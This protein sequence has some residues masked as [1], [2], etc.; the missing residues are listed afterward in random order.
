MGKDY[1][2]ILGLQKGASSDEIKKAFRKLASQYHPDKKT[3]DEAKFKEVSEAYAVLG[4][5]K[6]RAEYDTYGQSFAGGGGFNGF[7]WSN[8][9]GFGGNGVEFDLGDIFQNFG[10]M[11]GGFGR[12]ERRRGRD[13]SIDIELD[14]SEAVFGTKRKILLT[15][16]NV[17]VEC[18]GSGAKQGSAM[19]TCSTCNGQGKLREMRR[20]IMG[21]FTTVRECNVCHGKGQV[22]K[23]RC[24]ACAGEGVRRVEQEIDINIPNGVENGEM[25]RLTGQG[26]AVQNGVPGDLYVKLHVRPH[27]L[28]KRDGQNLLQNLSIK[29]SDALLGGNYKVETLDG[30]VEIK[31]PAGVRHGEM[32]RIKGKGV[33]SGSRRGDFLVRINIEIPNKLSR[34]AKKLIEELKNEGI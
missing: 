17:C 27:T 14:F 9:Q 13:I 1:Y 26:E 33:P 7:D 24:K 15:K 3:G 4:D 23:E 29:L 20:S 32:L 31:I 11:F 12:K 8:M 16:N 28:I 19:E 5:D 18:G 25:M 22:P 21:N 6:K 30:A 10:D 2:K 34:N